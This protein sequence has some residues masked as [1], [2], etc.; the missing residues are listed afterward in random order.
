MRETKFKYCVP[1]LEDGE[2]KSLS[3]SKA[4]PEGDP[5]H[6]NDDVD[7][8]INDAFKDI[9]LDEE[10]TK[11]T[12]NGDAHDQTTSDEKHLVY[13]EEEEDDS[14]PCGW[15][16]IRPRFIQVRYFF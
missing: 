10:N 15:F 14:A 13:E 1:F 5:V 7:G 11:P 16:S 2:D 4:S 8:L 12:S 3:E 6:S 9:D